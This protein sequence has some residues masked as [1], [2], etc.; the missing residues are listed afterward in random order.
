MLYLNN[1]DNPTTAART[2]TWIGNDGTAASLPVTSTVTVAPV[3]DG[4]TIIAGGTLGYTEG[5]PA[6]AIDPLLTVIDV[7][8]INLTGATVQITA[9]YQNVEDVLSF[10]TI[11]PITGSFD[12]PSGTLTLSGTDTVANYEAALRAVHYQ[13]TSIGPN[14]APRTVSWNATD[15]VTA[16]N[17]ATSTITIGVSTMPPLPPTTRWLWWKGERRLA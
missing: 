12:L 2:V 9:N 3:N 1:S 17:T 8:S 14:P 5:G 11:G 6:T 4:P 15:G 16:S 13:N 7:D 10:T